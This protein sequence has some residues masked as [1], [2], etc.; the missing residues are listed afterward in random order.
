MN[1]VPQTGAETKPLWSGFHQS[2]V[3][4]PDRSAVEVNGQVLTYAQLHN[5][6]ASLAATLLRHSPS[7]TPPLTAVFSNRSATAFAAVLG[8]LFRGH[9]YVPL[10]RAF[11]PQR[12]RFM[13]RHSRCRSLIVD[14]Q[15]EPQLEEILADAGDQMLLIFPDRDDVKDLARRWANHIVL[16]SSDLESPDVWSPPASSTNAM[17]Y[18]LFTSGSTGTPKAVMVSHS[19]VRHYLNWAV[20]RYQVTEEDRVSQIIDLGFDLSAH[21]MFVA[22]ERG[23]CVCCPTQKE[24]FKPSD[25]INDSRLT[26]WLSVPSTAVF[27][28][29]LGLLKPGKYPRLRLS[30]F[31][32]EALPAE[33]AKHWALA[34]PNSVM[35]NLY[36]PTELTIACTAY[37][38]DA[39]RSAVECEHG[40]VPIGEPFDGMEALIV[41]E[42]LREVKPGAAGELLMTGP[43]L[44][45]GYWQ[46]EERTARAFVAPPGKDRVY[47]RTGDRVRRPL[48]G[49]PMTYLG[50]MDNQIKILGQRVE[51]GEVEAVVRAESGVD[52]V[53]ALGW[54]INSSGADGIEV[55]LESEGIDLL[56]LQNRVASRLPAY[57]VPRRI[58]LLPELPVNTNGKFDRQALLRILEAKSRLCTDPELPGLMNLSAGSGKPV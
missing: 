30:L 3:T 38:W 20:N 55:F 36:G 13:L 18:L 4:F 24:R 10:D 5:K 27:M 32:G 9:G 54:P 34:T 56:Q 29:R 12:S 57:M 43:Q 40:I 48:A 7:E 2:A 52:G 8:A 22:W 46:D 15:S 14:D 58:H 23:A 28:R 16:G 31:C 25:F 33:T 49:K 50:R 41:D 42:Q 53:V 45:L 47:Y 6:A 19:N 26:M 11:P 17:A 1:Q 39:A 37:R 51:L 35:E 44:S 21:D